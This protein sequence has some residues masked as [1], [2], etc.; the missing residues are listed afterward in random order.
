[1]TA[2]PKATEA[3]LGATAMHWGL[4][5][6]RAPTSGDDDA[7]DACGAEGARA[8]EAERTLADA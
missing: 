3:I 5:P 1:M 6:E 8:T 4:R 7:A 2:M